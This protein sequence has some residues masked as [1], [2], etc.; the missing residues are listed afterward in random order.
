MKTIINNQNQYE[1]QD[2]YFGML[3]DVRNTFIGYGRYL[4]RNNIPDEGSIEDYENYLI[5]QEAQCKEFEVDDTETFIKNYYDNLPQKTKDY[6]EF[7]DFLLECQTWDNDIVIIKGEDWD[8]FYNNFDPN[9]ERDMNLA[10]WCD[11]DKFYDKFAEITG[12]EKWKFESWF[13]SCK[14][15]DTYTYNT[16]N[17]IVNINGINQRFIIDR[18]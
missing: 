13:I 5:F 7:F 18:V 14:Y 12:T 4:E 3:E 15:I 6:M 11:A 9:E 16:M 1:R 17:L 2:Y 8:E 10:G